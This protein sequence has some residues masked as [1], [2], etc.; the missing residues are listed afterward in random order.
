MYAATCAIA[1]VTCGGGPR[2]ASVPCVQRQR[3]GQA[4]QRVKCL[5]VCF[6]QHYER[7]HHDS[8]R[9]ARLVRRM[10]QR[11]GTCISIARATAFVTGRLQTFQVCRRPNNDTCTIVSVS[12]GPEVN[13]SATIQMWQDGPM[14]LQQ[15]LPCKIAVYRPSTG[16]EQRPPSKRCAVDGPKALLSGDARVHPCKVRGGRQSP[17]AGRGAAAGATHEAWRCGGRP[18]TQTILPLLPPPAVPKATWRLGTA[19]QRT[20]ARH[21]A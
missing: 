10:A 6:V 15:K 5:V 14:A 1:T 21:H 11:C 3:Q 13:Q 18:E 17:H 20:P 2:C 12:F 7:R 9:E 4:M 16:T 19:V 8:R